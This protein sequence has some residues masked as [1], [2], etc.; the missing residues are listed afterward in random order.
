M[1]RYRYVDEPPA[2]SQQWHALP[3]W[4]LPSVR[5]HGSGRSEHV[6]SELVPYPFTAQERWQTDGASW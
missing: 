5:R 3:W 1:I 6:N 2:T 4:N